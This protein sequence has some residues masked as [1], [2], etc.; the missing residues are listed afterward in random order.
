MAQP[1]YSDQIRARAIACRQ[2]FLDR[3]E[4]GETSKIGSETPTGE[5]SAIQEV[6][7]LTTFARV[8]ADRSGSLDLNEWWEN[9]WQFELVFD[10]DRDGRVSRDEYLSGRA[11]RSEPR[12]PDHRDFAGWMEDYDERRF[13]RLSS[14][15]FL[16]REKLA[17]EVRADFRRNDL[18]RDGQVTEEERREAN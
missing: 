2:H 18:N 11:R 8:D 3:F 17:R 15:G 13:N 14:R 5:R 12:D 16:G 1:D 9:A 7:E 6:F 10:V 4:A